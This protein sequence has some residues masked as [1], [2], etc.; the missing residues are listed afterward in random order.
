MNWI[1]NGSKVKETHSK[2]TG[3]VRKGDINDQWQ[4]RTADS[5]G[6]SVRLKSADIH[7]LFGTSKEKCRMRYIGLDV[8]KDNITACVLTSTDGNFTFCHT[9][10][11]RSGKREQLIHFQKSLEEYGCDHMAAPQTWDDAFDRLKRVISD[12][13]S[14]RKVVFIANHRP[15]PKTM[16]LSLTSSERACLSFIIQFGIMFSKSKEGEGHDWQ[17]W[18]AKGT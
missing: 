14:P 9:G 7:S 1:R 10:K 15:L 11:S 16:S 18:W 2:R 6:L 13:V 17:N 5:S 12:S 3:T 8:H 4:K